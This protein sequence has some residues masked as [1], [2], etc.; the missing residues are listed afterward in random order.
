[1]ATG[2]TPVVPGNGTPGFSM[3]IERYEPTAKAWSALVSSP[4]N[5]V[6]LALTPGS[7]NGDV[8]WFMEV[9]KGEQV[10]YRDQA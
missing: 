1:M 8:L 4:A 6:L 5:G 2:P 7:T 10:L 3:S 9:N